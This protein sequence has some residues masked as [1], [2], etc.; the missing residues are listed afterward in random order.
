MQDY[1][2]VVCGSGSA[3]SLAAARFSENLAVRALLIEA[4]GSRDSSEVIT[5][6]KWQMNLGSERDWG[7]AAQPNP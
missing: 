2:F 4:R 3:A 6:G 5:S 7:F 1:G